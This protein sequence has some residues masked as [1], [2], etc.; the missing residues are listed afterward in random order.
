MMLEN[1]VRMNIMFSCIGEVKS[2]YDPFITE[3][4]VSFIINGTMEITEGDKTMTF[5]EG[6]IVFISKNQIIKIKKVPNQKPFIALSIILPKEVL[7]KFA[8]KHHVEP[9][10]VYIGNANFMIPNNYFLEGYLSSMVP[11]FENPDALTDNLAQYKALEL[12]EIL[13]QDTRM[14]NILFTF[15]ADFKLDLNAYMNK[16]FM[17]NLPLK[18]FATLTGRSLS[19]FKRDFQETFQTTPN[20]WLIKKRLDLAYHLISNK[21]KKPS[22]AY[23]DAGFVN[24]SHFSKSFKEEFGINPSEI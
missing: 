19:S 8:K 9:K 23:I 7:Y 15:A 21:G 17:H 16:Y 24:F 11:Y 12:I 3:H 14:Q 1:R 22:E 18:Q 10:G 4:A 5:S 20:K 2:D 6:N 13:K